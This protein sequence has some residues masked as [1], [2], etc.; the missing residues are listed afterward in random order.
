MIISKEYQRPSVVLSEVQIR[1]Q[2]THTDLFFQRQQVAIFFVF[3][4]FTFK[5]RRSQN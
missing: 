3:L 5:L 1:G 4:A 2:R